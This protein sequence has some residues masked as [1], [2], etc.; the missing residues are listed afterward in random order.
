VTDEA[1]ALNAEAIIAVLNAHHVDY[2][3]IGA[4][5]AQACGSPRRAA[6]S[7]PDFG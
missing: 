1:P 3:V 5:A 4:F 6:S 7:A 2:V